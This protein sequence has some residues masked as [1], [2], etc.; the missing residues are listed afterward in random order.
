MMHSRLAQ[1]VSN[2]IIFSGVL[3]CGEYIYLN[4]ALYATVLTKLVIY[5]EKHNK[6]VTAKYTYCREERKYVLN[7]KYIRKQ[8]AKLGKK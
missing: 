6:K 8:K 1:F 5:V 7:K 2:A 3:V 4:A